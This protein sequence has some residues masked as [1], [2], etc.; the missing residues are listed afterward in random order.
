MVIKVQL[1]L[2]EMSL[3]HRSLGADFLQPRHLL[4]KTSRKLLCFTSKREDG[5]VANSDWFT[6][7][8]RIGS[9]CSLLFKLVSDWYAFQCAKNNCLSSWRFEVDTYLLCYS[10]WRKFECVLLT[11]AL[12]VIIIEILTLLRLRSWSSGVV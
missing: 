10:R 2:H 11:F 3:L 6:A 12:D 1:S 9:Q 5:W 7:F 4:K 8:A